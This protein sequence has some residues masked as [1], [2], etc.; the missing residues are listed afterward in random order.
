V[1]EKMTIPVGGWGGVVKTILIMELIN[2]IA[3]AHGA[4]LYLV[5]Q[6]NGGLVKKM[7]FI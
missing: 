2:N 5:E 1:E 6:G 4:Y 7:I 3:K